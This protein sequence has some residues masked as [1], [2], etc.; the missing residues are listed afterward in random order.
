MTVGELGKRM[1]SGELAR[2]VAHDQLTQFEHEM[3]QREAEMKA[4]ARGGR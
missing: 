3:A 1:S 2:W 4:R